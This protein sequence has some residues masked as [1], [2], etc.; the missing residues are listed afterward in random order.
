MQ[1]S[2]LAAGG[3]PRKCEMTPAYIREPTSYTLS[4]LLV[5]YCSGAAG[6]ET[7]SRFVDGNFCRFNRRFIVLGCFAVANE[8][9]DDR[10]RGIVNDG[11]NLKCDTCRPLRKTTT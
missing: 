2:G 6:L 3:C 10:V 4:R 5:V 8:A 1:L 7:T 11:G 9:R